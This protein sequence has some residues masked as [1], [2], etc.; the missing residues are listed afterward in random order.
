MDVVL[1]VVFGVVFAVRVAEGADRPTTFRAAAPALLTKDR[2]PVVAMTC[3][4]RAEKCHDPGRVT[5]VIISGRENMWN[6]KAL[7]AAIPGK[8]AAICPLVDPSLR[9][10]VAVSLADWSLLHDIDGT[11][12]PSYDQERAGE[13]ASPAARRRG[14]D[15]PGV[16]GRKATAA[17]GGRLEPAAA[18]DEWVGTFPPGTPPAKEGGTAGAPGRRTRT[19][20]PSRGETTNRP[21]RSDAK[22]PW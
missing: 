22:D 9:R 1:D 15:Q 12:S 20:V 14:E 7:Q 4:H 8:F 10:V 16:A 17:S 3:P 5:R 21:T 18:H 13:G 11:S 19:L 6:V 2:L